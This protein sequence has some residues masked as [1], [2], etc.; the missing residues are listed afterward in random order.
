MPVYGGGQAPLAASAASAS[1]TG[2]SA[3]V[4]SAALATV[5]VPGG[6][7]GKNGRLRITSMWS[8]TNHASNK[9][10][11]IRF[12]GNLFLDAV[13]TTSAAVQQSTIIRNNA[14]ASVQK[15]YAIANVGGFGSTTAAIKTDT[16]NTNNDQTITFH[17]VLA[18]TSHTVTLEDYMVE[19]LFQP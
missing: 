1:H 12:G 6:S 17:A 16:I 7:M 3:G 8:Y 18:D 9:T 2:G 15:A 10:L 19:V 11:R 14:S 13:V 5:T 4:E